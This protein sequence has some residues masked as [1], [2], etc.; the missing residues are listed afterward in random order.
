MK[1]DSESCADCGIDTTPC[2]G[3]RGCRHIGR[4]EHY[5]VHDEVWS[6]ANGARFLCVGCIEQRLGRQL[7]AEDFTGA[8]INDAD[9]WDTPR[10]AAR[11]LTFW[12]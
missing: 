2:T 3:K 6:V 11:K 8:P 10:L 9:P 12:R 5:M 4:W 7:T 1:V